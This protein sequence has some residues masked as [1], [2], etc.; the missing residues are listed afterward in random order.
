MGKI[1]EEERSCSNCYAKLRCPSA[2]AGNSCHSHMF[3]AEQLRKEMGEPFPTK[4]KDN[5]NLDAGG[6][7]FDDEKPRF[8][9]IP[10]EAITE[11]AKLMTMGAKKY[12]DRNWEKGMRWGRTFAAL[13]RH[14]WKFWN[15][16]EIDPETGVHHMVAVIWNAVA[17]YTFV[18]R[19]IGEDDRNGGYVT[20]E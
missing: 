19:G 20:I 3:L 11:L 12:D 2:Y 18:A 7:K 1:I 6:V 4:S 13:N 8:D 14:L 10:P 15:G 9:L 5:M 16:Q 17:L